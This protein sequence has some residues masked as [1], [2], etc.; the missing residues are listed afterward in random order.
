MIKHALAVALLGIGIGF[1]GHAPAHAAPPLS[2]AAASSMRTDDAVVKVGVRCLGELPV[3]VIGVVFFQLL[4]DEEIDRHCD[5]RFDDN[6]H[7]RRTYNARDYRTYKDGGDAQP[8]DLK[9]SLR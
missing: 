8:K 4:G 6:D 2:G 7:D 5:G 1:T 9:G 3:V